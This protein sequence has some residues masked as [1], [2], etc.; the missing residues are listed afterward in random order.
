MKRKKRAE[1]SIESLKDRIKEHII[2]LLHDELLPQLVLLPK[3]Q[4]PAPWPNLALKPL[5]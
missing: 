3:E 5:L 1:K 2:K 4:P